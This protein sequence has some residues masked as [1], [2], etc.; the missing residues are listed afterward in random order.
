MFQK[1]GFKRGY[2]GLSE[3]E[4]EEEEEEGEG[5]EGEN[6]SL[7]KHP[8]KH[9]K[10]VYLGPGLLLIGE[11]HPDL[12]WV[13]LRFSFPNI[14]YQW[15]FLMVL[16]ETLKSNIGKKLYLHSHFFQFFY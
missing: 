4:G 12:G 2:W 1:R 14:L 13:I 6:S 16:C 11:R 9:P 3:E 15:R 5:E 8:K 10:K 7:R